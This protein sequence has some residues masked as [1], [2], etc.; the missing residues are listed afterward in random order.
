M[1]DQRRSDVN[2]GASVSNTLAKIK[3]IPWADTTH[4]YE[5]GNV[6]D[7]VRQKPPSFESRPQAH[8]RDVLE[9][10]LLRKP[11]FN[12]IARISG[13]FKAKTVLDPACSTGLLLESVTAGGQFDVIHGVEDHPVPR[14]VSKHLLG[15]QARIFPLDPGSS[16]LESALTPATE[17]A[18]ATAETI[19]HSPPQEMLSHYDLIVSDPPLGYRLKTDIANLGTTRYDK[20]TALTAWACD[21]LTETG[22]VLITVG[23]SFL[24]RDEKRLNKAITDRGC[25]VRA[26]IHLPHESIS[27]HHHVKLDSYL[28]VIERG[29][30]QDIFVGQYKQSPSH[31]EALLKNLERNKPDKNIRLGR[32]CA[33]HDFHDYAAFL[34]QEK[35]RKLAKV[36]GWRGVAAEDV[37]LAHWQSRRGNVT[38]RDTDAMPRDA[39]SCYLTLHGEIKTTLDP[40]ELS[41]SS[42]YVHLKFNPERVDPQFFVRWVSSPLGRATLDTVSSSLDRLLQTKFHLPPIDVQRKTVRVADQIQN[43]R[44]ELAEIETN[45]WSG[46]SPVTEL[47]DKISSFSIDNTFEDWIESLP[48]PLAAILHRVHSHS[49]AVKGLDQV[50]KNNE[51]LFLFFEATTAFLAIVHLSAF[52]NSSD[53]WR[54]HGGNLMNLLRKHNHSLERATQGTWMIIHNH[55]SAVELKEKEPAKRDLYRTSSSDVLSMLADPELRT[56]LEETNSLRNEKKGHRG[57]SDEKSDRELREKLD[58]Y[59]HR[60]RSVFRGTWKQYELLQGTGTSVTDKVGVKTW[61]VR[62]LAGSNPNF[63]EIDCVS[64]EELFQDELFMFDVQDQTALHIFPPLIKVEVSDADVDACYIYSSCSSAGISR[65]LSYDFARKSELKNSYPD[66]NQALALLNAVT[67]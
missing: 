42:N 5:Q 49:S 50:A 57:A 47:D 17:R 2:P 41:Q 12:F 24:F 9:A 58:S 48:Y 28:V 35:V 31:Q 8:T 62:K 29:K 34:A 11:F 1:L 18:A 39:T 51:D 61:R 30:T 63:S 27:N 36:A 6:I 16:A 66:V 56:I 55:L 13:L 20:A 23:P 59:V 64:H 43:A 19:L 7:G 15:D 10:H 52:G 60:L 25:R 22:A 38:P 65:F 21:R 33:R 37:I 40:N 44:D 4:Y 46:S 3:A 32:L 53:L 26:I 45:L 14:V 67:S 54:D